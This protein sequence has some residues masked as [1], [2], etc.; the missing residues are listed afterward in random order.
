[1]IDPSSNG[2]MQP[3][4]QLDPETVIRAW[5]DPEF[6]ATLPADVRRMIPDNP[7]GVARVSVSAGT[8][9]HFL[10]TVGCTTANCPSTLGCTTEN[11]PSTLGCATDNCPSTLGCTTRRC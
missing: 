2:P 9:T 8:A 6:A 1:M 10:S 11:C 4:G 7:A 5:R 3:G